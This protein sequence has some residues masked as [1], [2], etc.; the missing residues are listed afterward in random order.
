MTEIVPYTGADW[1]GIEKAHDAARMQELRFA[2]LTDAFLPLSVAAEREGLFE[3]TV[4]VARKDGTAVGFTAF[5][6]DE[7]AWLYVH[8]D[9]Q[10]QGIG[11][12]LAC[13]ALDRMAP[14]EQAVE[15][16]Q[17]NEPARQ[18]YKSLGFRRE[19]LLHGTMPGNE[20]FGVSVWQ[21]TRE[22]A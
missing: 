13:A 2:G 1:E 18:L 22:E 9:H 11:R 17:G 14:G 16:L 5:T 20:Q 15:V 12:R 10:G 19:R 8:P 4:L 3:Y 21:M 7:L 6:E